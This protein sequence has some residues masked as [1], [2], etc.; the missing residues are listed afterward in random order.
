MSTTLSPIDMSPNPRTRLSL[1]DLPP[2]AVPAIT[3]KREV[4][5]YC[6][7]AGLRTVVGGEL[8]WR[9][10]TAAALRTY[11]VEVAPPIGDDLASLGQ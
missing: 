2:P 7:V 10:A 3:D 9:D 4:E 8:C 6:V 5:G 11:L 1:T